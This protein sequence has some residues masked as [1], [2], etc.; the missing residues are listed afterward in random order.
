MTEH[1]TSSTSLHPWINEDGSTNVSGFVSAYRNWDNAFWTADTGHIQNVLDEAIDLL[2][3]A[4]RLTRAVIHG[5]GL[6][7]RIATFLGVNDD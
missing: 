6:D 5:G 2:E 7:V 4:Y 3:D 1:A